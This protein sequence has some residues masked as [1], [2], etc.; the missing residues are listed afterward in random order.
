VTAIADATRLTNVSW[1]AV[2]D[3]L[4]LRGDVPPR[5]AAGKAGG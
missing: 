2:G 4:L 3:D 5:P 1:E